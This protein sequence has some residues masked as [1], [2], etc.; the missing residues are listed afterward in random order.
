MGSLVSM[1]WS[2]GGSCCTEWWVDGG[3]NASGCAIGG[4]G[5]D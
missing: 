5:G 2:A 4:Y 1:A 3:S